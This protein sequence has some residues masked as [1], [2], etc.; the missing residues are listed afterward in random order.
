MNNIVKNDVEE[1][2]NCD[3][4]W[5]YFKN[6]KIFLTG[7]SGFYGSYILKTLVDAN[8]K[9]NLS[10]NISISLR[11]PDAFISKLEI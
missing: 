6:K 7:A 11:N 2:I 4:D 1:I 9:F 10:L 8:K 3:I 5:G